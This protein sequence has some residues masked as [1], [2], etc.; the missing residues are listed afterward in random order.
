MVV[1]VLACRTCPPKFSLYCGYVIQWG[2]KHGGQWTSVS[3]DSHVLALASLG[4]AQLTQS[5]PS[6]R[7]VI[8]PR[9]GCI[10]YLSVE[11]AGRCLK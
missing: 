3:S 1:G 5:R 11:A 8:G 9:A 2:F 6:L 7:A 4:L 10:G